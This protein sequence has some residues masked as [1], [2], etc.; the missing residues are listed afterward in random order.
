MIGA[1][2]A[3]AVALAVAA[4][5]QVDVSA[6]PGSQAETAVAVAPAD[7]HV[8]LAA[9]NQ[10]GSGGFDT[11]TYGS[12]DGG[13]TWTTSRPFSGGGSDCAIGDPVPAIDNTGRQ[14][15]AYLVVP[16]GDPDPERDISLY[17]SARD[18][19]DGPWTPVRVADPAGG[20]NDKPA[21][22][23]DTSAAG[24]HSGRAYLAW[25]KISRRR[26]NLVVSHSDDGGATWSEPAPLSPADGS[27]SAAFFVSLSVAPDGDLYA[28]WEDVLRRVFVARSTDGGASFGPLESVGAAAGLPTG[29]CR[30]DGTTIP[31]QSSRCVTVNPNVVAGAEIV[32]VVYAASGV[33]GRQLDVR[34]RS[35]SRDLQPLGPYVRIHPADG[36]IVSDQF[37]PVAA[38][39]PRTGVVWACYYDTRGDRTRRSARFTCTASR[40]GGR[41]WAAPIAVASVRSDETRT[42]ATR[43]QFGDYQGV[44]VGSDGV[45]HPVWTDSRDL[46]SRGEE[47]YTTSL[48]AAVFGY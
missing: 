18:G 32:T 17:V 15:I 6:Q 12:T 30:L 48:S 2:A 21:L 1:A 26:L 13:A 41:T 36:K 20:P 11:L 27:G 31:A 39:D 23:V 7:P 34:A 38:V 19:P 37:Q 22:A 5:P 47:I 16:C 45:A 3:A 35:F 29:G 28:A 8:L 9:S 4:P 42:P 10:L 33:R 43:F 14:L 44:A 40:D 24:P 25:N 46:R